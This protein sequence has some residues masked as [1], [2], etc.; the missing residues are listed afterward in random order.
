MVLTTLSTAAAGVVTPLLTLHLLGVATP[1]PSLPLLLAY[2]QMALLPLAAA[3][4]VRDVFPRHTR[5]VAA[6]APLVRVIRVPW[7]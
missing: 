4:L 3:V 1:L 5:A 7:G 2:G 6:A